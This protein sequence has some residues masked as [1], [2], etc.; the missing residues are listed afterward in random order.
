MSHPRRHRHR[1]H[2]TL[3]Q[4]YHFPYTHVRTLPRTHAWTACQAAG[5]H[6]HGILPRVR[7]RRRGARPPWP[8]AWE[9]EVM[10]LI[11]KP[12]NKTRYP[13]LRTLGPARASAPMRRRRPQATI[14]INSR[15]PPTAI[16]AA[17]QR[18]AP[19]PPPRPMP[20]TRPPRAR[21]AR[22]APTGSRSSRCDC[23]SRASPPSATPFR[24]PHQPLR[25]PSVASAVRQ[26][27]RL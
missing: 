15:P 11:L 25:R 8:G 20:S 22:A 26:G 1:C 6:H 9:L 4:T 27:S 12:N 21:A 19:A 24:L 13:Q 5:P 2:R 10:S 23:S 17:R 18:C 14:A 7:A 3:R 16:P